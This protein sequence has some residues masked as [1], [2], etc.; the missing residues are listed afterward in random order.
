M[1]KNTRRTRASRAAITAAP[2]ASSRL[3]AAELVADARRSIAGAEL[4]IA[5]GSLAGAVVLLDDAS[6]C[7]QAI[8]RAGA[9]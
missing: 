5:S 2:I 7:I 9:G 8:W 3:S 4:A 1:G 6:A